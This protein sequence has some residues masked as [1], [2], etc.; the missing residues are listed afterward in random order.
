MSRLRIRALTIVAG[1]AVVAAISGCDLQE[2]ADVDNGRELFV[3]N[4]GSCHIL[5]EA[6]TSGNIGPDLDAAFADARTQ[7]MD[8][9]TIEGVVESQIFYPR[10]PPGPDPESDPTFMPANLVTGDDAR[11]VAAYVGRVAG[12]PG[13][14]PPQAPGGPGGQVYAN[15]GC[16][17]CHIFAPAQSQGQ[18]GPNLDEVLE[19]QSAAQI[20]RSIVDPEAEI[21]AGFD[22]GVM[23][24][25]YG[26]DITPEDLEL[27]VEFLQSGGSGGGNG[28]G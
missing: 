12:V 24:A 14:E 10:Q 13:I 20:E 3:E 22:G 21:S 25:T 5:Q 18:V 19:G 16:G 9:D 27:L 8:Q 11:D 26:D 6:A 7:G 15:N 28:G 4:C 2:N 1:A 23:P 17:A